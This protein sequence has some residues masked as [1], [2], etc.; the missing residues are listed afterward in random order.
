MPGLM[1]T[2]LDTRA[3]EME[4]RRSRQTAGRVLELVADEFGVERDSL[5]LT[6]RFQEE[7]GVNSLDLMEL[8]MKLEETF[9]VQIPDQ[10]VTELKTVEHLVEL[11]LRPRAA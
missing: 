6:S 7:I 3:C 5:Q 9:S 10:A 8:I 11:V 2:S 4:Q 1:R